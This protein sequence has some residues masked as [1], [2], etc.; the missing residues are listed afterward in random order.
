[1]A[2]RHEDGNA[3]GRGDA[4]VRPVLDVGEEDDLALDGRETRQRGEDPSA[5]VRALERLD[6]R[7]SVR[8]GNR[9]VERNESPPTDGAKAVQGSAVD[10][11]E[12]PGRET[13]GLP[14][15]G[16]LFVG[17]H[18]G[19]LRDVVGVGRVTEDGERAREGGAAVTSYQRRERVLDAR[20][21]AVNQLFV[22]QL[23]RHVGNRTP[24]GDET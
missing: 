16:E 21:R 19:L 7:V 23:G 10:D 22:G 24:I 1:M 3:G 4:I 12:Q 15:G 9:F 2:T 11:G 18:E 17:V 20:Q 5:Q 13:R 8:R 14:A 6:R